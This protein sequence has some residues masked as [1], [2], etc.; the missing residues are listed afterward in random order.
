MKQFKMAATSPKGS[1]LV[2]LLEAQHAVILTSGNHRLENAG[3]DAVKG[4][5]WGGSFF[6]IGEITSL[7]DNFSNRSR[8]F[9]RQC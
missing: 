6:C 1:I 4:R 3:L 9:L 8:K 2:K 5:Y 7:H